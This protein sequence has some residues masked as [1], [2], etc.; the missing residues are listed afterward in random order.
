MVG[1]T[2][3][4]HYTD[5]VTTVNNRT[6]AYQITAIDNFLNRSAT[7][8]LPAVKISH[9][10]NY[11][12]SLWTVTTNMTSEADTVPGADEQDPCEPAPVSAISQVIDND[13]NTTYT[14]TA[15]GEAVITLNFHKTLAGHRLPVH[16]HI[17]HAHR[18][19]RT[20][21]HR[22]RHPVAD[23]GH[24]HFRRGIRSTPSTSP[25]GTA[26]PG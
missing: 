4:G 23:P 10:G 21:V 19:V 9:K 26:T 2:T 3:D 5:T 25:T 14:G 1:F 22:R 12:K 8:T 18:R 16:R 17:G 20:A 11:D 13:K 6:V 15:S 24:R 7:R